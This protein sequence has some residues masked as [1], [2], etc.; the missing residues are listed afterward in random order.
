MCSGKLPT[1]SRH[2]AGVITSFSVAPL[3]VYT[4]PTVLSTCPRGIS[5]PSLQTQSHLGRECVDVLV[6]IYLTEMISFQA[7]FPSVGWVRSCLRLTRIQHRNWNIKNTEFFRLVRKKICNYT[8]L[9]LNPGSA[10]YKF[11]ELETKSH[12]QHVFL[13]L[14][15]GYLSHS[16]IRKW[17]LITT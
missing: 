9:G 5:H 3:T 13:F 7:L 10:I 12:S 1:L 17:A 15:W 4:S 14:K 2:W 8:N 11:Y 16:Y 6:F